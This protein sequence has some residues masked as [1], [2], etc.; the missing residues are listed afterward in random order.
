MK[1]VLVIGD[2]LHVFK[3][4]LFIKMEYS[5]YFAAKSA[6]IISRSLSSKTGIDTHFWFDGLLLSVSPVNRALD[7]MIFSPFALHVSRHY[8][9]KSYGDIGHYY[10]KNSSL[11]L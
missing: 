11:P 9:L 8:P 3:V 1:S 7:V 4:D 6:H 2:Y 10:P 5:L